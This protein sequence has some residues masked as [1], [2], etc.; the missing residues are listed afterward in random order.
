[1]SAVRLLA[2]GESNPFV[3]PPTQI[4][5]RI[6]GERV[7]CRGSELSNSL[8]RTKLTYSLRKQLKLWTGTRLGCPP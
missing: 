1:M 4:G 2:T 3:I 6:G 8:G 7:T 5:F